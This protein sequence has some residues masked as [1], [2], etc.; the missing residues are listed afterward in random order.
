MQRGLNYDIHPQKV[1]Y[2]KF[3][4]KTT[5]NEGYSEYIV[6]ALQQE[7]DLM[8]NEYILLIVK[9]NAPFPEIEHVFTLDNCYYC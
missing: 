2:E 6:D 1:I 5:K 8:K 7:D 4:S 9:K 3:K